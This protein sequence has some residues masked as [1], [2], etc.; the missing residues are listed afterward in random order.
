MSDVR[1]YRDRYGLP[2]TA[3]SEAAVARHAA[4]LDRRLSADAGAVECLQQAI[5]ADPTFALAHADLA[6]VLQRLGR[7]QPAAESQARAAAL[8]GGLTP[9]EGGHIDGVG[10][11]VAGDHVRGLR[12]ICG[13]LEAY[14]RDALLLQ[15]ATLLMASGVS[16]DGDARR[17]RVALLERL[18]P[19][20]G[21]DWAFL[22]LLGFALN[23]L[24]RNDEARRLV[25]RSLAQNP[26][27]PA[28]AH[29]YAHVF[30]ETGDPRG[31]AEFLDG[32]LPGCDPR[33]T[34]HVHN[35]WHLAVFELQLGRFGRAMAAYERGVSPARPRSG[36]PTLIANG[37]VSLLW[38]ALLTGY[39][40]AALP[41]GPARDFAAHGSANAGPLRALWDAYEAAAYAGAEDGAGLSLLQARLH[42]ADPAVYPVAGPVVL[43]LAD[44]LWAFAAEDWGAASDLLEPLAARLVGLG[45]SNEQRDAFED[46]C[47]AAAV[48]AGRRALAEAHLR[49]R[50]ARRPSGQDAL[51][52]AQVL[53]ASGREAE[54]ANSLDAAEAAWQAADPDFPGL[55]RLKRLREELSLGSG[56]RGG[57]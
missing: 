21:D 20:Y 9:R 5:A 41:W 30:Y 2:L 14:P 37:S 8:A 19:H 4:F 7:P 38:R 16:L 22:N 51:W 54:A 26:R 17:E 29:T 43:P 57:T 39:P 11:V 47:V 53:A 18:A 55:A 34:F 36:P 48:R 46:T 49:R 33:A 23:E 52:L 25:E 12:L 42:A 35:S 56:G 3:A 44:A 50:L 1:V 28:A 32:W 15:E 10:A 27:N 13:H 24:G 45:G 6:L 31:G 40:A